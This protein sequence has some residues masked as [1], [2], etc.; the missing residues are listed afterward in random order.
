MEKNYKTSEE[1][2]KYIRA[3]FRNFILDIPVEEW[4]LR[5]SNVVFRMAVEKSASARPATQRTG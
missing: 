5:C 1:L 2:A 4:D 3:G